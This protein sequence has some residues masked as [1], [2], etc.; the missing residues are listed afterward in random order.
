MKNK[1]LV[2]K[3]YENVQSLRIN[4]INSCEQ[5]YS[6]DCNKVVYV[7]SNIVLDNHESLVLERGPPHDLTI[8]PDSPIYCF[9]T[10]KYIFLYGASR[11]DTAQFHRH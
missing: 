7:M 10:N 5:Q 9:V 8:F 3:I 1:A 4:F 2:N 11:I 6:V